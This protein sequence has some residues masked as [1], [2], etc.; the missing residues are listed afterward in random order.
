M[1]YLHGII[2]VED[3]IVPHNPLSELT[4]EGHP[5]QTTVKQCIDYAQSGVG[6]LLIEYVNLAAA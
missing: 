3:I 1:R 5:Q 4:R 2:I 6:I